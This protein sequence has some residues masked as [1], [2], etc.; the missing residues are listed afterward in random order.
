MTQNDDTI[1]FHATAGAF[2]QADH[3]IT[4]DDLSRVFNLYLPFIGATS[5]ALYH[6]L[7]N[8]LPFNHEQLK[9]QDHNFII[10]SLNISLPNFVKCRRRLEAAGLMKT[11]YEKDA[12]GEVYGY[13]LL[14]PLASDKFFKE[15]LLSGLL[16]KFVGEERYLILEK[17][18]GIQGQEQLSGKNISARFLQVFQNKNDLSVPKTPLVYQEATIQPDETT[19]KFDDFTEM[20]RGTRVATIEKH[21]NFLVAMHITY[22]V[23][24]ITLAGFVNQSITL[25]THEINEQEVQRLLRQQVTRNVSV[26]KVS[27]EPQQAQN[28]PEIK[29]TEAR[30]LIEIASTTNAQDFLGYV[31]TTL[32]SGLVLKKERDLVDY[33][34]AQ[35]TLTMPVVNILVHYVLIGLQNDSLKAAL[36]TTIADSW[37]Q[38]RV[39][40]PEKALIQIQQRQKA[41]QERQEKRFSRHAKPEKTTPKFVTKPSTSNDTISNVTV[42]TDSAAAAL[43]KLKNIKTKN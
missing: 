20:I 12:M 14:T 7:V 31:K 13:R 3:L 23:D 4:P 27:P 11:V 8:E 37:T 26:N 30:A 10:D 34:I 42:E 29:N 18:Y 16:Y 17:R 32:K 19:F 35:S 39:D 2:F 9:R 22:G 43:A 28:V 40:T 36:V 25:D 5:Y 1:E 38:N 41:N 6:L 33:L 15:Q 24:E 21:R